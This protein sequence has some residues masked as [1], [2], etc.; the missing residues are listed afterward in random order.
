MNS[1]ALDH[2]LTAYAVC[3][4]PENKAAIVEAVAPKL[5]ECRHCGFYVALNQAPTPAQPAAVSALIEC[6]LCEGSGEQFG[7]FACENCDGLGMIP[8]DVSAPTDERELTDD[9]IEL[10]RKGLRDWELPANR[11]AAQTVLDRLA[12]T[13]KA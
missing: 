4:T 2:A 9:D 8:A 1:L 10:L 12:T 3:P 5:T 6:P 7:S 11:Y 13:T